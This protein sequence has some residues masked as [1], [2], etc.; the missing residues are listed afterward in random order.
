MNLIYADIL[1]FYNKV[2]I[3]DAGSDRFVSDANALIR[4]SMRL[5]PLFDTYLQNEGLE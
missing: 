2:M 3:W 5:F 1:G 4:G